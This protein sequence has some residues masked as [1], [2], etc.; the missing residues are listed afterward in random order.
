MQDDRGL[1][2]LASIDR[3]LALLTA[4]HERELRVAFES[5]ILR[6]EGRQRMWDR[7]NGQRST[8]EI[9]KEAGS[10]LRVTQIFVKEML[11]AGFV[12]DTQT[13]G[14]RAVIVDRDEEAILRWYVMR[15]GGS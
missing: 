6:S 4:T 7:I 10:N 11:D 2:L 13:G 9:A 5:E 15:D 3:R 12:K 1:R 8:A 14:G